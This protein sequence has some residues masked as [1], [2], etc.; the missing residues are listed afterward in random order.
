M[1]VV[2][3]VIEARGRP[4]VIWIWYLP[5]AVAVVSS[6]FARSPRIGDRDGQTNG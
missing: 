6:A 4:T 2:V 5:V 3:D 1:V